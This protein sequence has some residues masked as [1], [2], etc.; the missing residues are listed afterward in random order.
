MNQ[1]IK[2]K[3]TAALRSGEY[4]QAHFALNVDG[5]MCCLGVLC[6]LYR[7]EHPDGPD[8]EFRVAPAHP[9]MM[10]QVQGKELGFFDGEENCAPQSVQGW[11]GLEDGNPQLGRL[12][13]PEHPDIQ[14][15][16][17]Y[18]G[19]VSAASLNDSGLTFPQM[20]DM[21]DHFL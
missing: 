7:K 15:E 3:W 17:K 2:T 19:V 1:E 9:S 16:L 4:K 5:G 11:A 8:W 12:E 14:D 13:R 18:C 20:A 21:I 10:K 6:D